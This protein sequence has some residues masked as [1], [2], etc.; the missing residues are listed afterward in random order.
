MLPQDS[1]P[2]GFCQC[3][4]GQQTQLAT[5]TSRRF[6]RRKGEPQRYIQGHQAALAHA[7]QRARNEQ[8]VRERFWARVEKTA[9]CWL[10]RGVLVHT[11][12][13]HFKLRGRQQ[14]AHRVAWELAGRAIPDGYQLDHLCRVRACVNPD[15]LEAVTPRENQLRGS[16]PVAA[17]ARKTHCIHG[18]L[19]SGENLFYSQR[20]RQCRA[21]HR[22]RG[23][24]TARRRAG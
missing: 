7:A 1:I 17:N 8:T 16:S 9:T 10:W 2:T 22:R 3:G 14:Y 5:H 23:R 24:E 19:L 6:N 20:K 4:C 18:H 12:Y 21:C 13:G 11:G 15:H